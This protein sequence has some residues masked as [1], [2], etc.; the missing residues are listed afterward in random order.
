MSPA[1]TTTQ[2]PPVEH[3]EKGDLTRR[4]I[5]DT[6]ATAFARSGYAG[7]SLNDL[8]KAA[9]ITKGGFYFHFPS[10]EALALAV[11]QDKQETWLRDISAAALRH[12]R[13]VDQLVAVADALCDLYDRDPAFG[14]MSKLCREMGLDHRPN[15]GAKPHGGAGAAEGVRRSPA[16]G[17]A[18]PVGQ[19]STHIFTTWI[20]FTA[21]LIERGQAEGDLRTDVDP[22]AAAETAVASFLGIKDMADL[23]SG[24]ADLRRRMQH[25]TDLFM[26]AL[27]VDQTATT[28][29]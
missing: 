24:G 16:A 17:S 20:R 11:V 29:D 22:I 19:A 1:A 18:T 27:R 21:A 9:G 10:K 14:S 2:S 25:F 4:H 23:M 26:T 28:N 6:A 3:T 7:T 15:G 5:L 12:T 8:I 13:A